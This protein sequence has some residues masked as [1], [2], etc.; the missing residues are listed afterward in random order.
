MVFSIRSQLLY[1]TC[2]LIIQVSVSTKSPAEINSNPALINQLTKQ[3]NQGK[4]SYIEHKITPKHDF[5]KN[6]VAGFSNKPLKTKPKVLKIP[7]KVRADIIY[8]NGKKVIYDLKGKKELILKKILKKQNTKE[9]FWMKKY[10]KPQKFI[11]KIKEK[12]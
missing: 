3:L 8:K 12:L 4:S 6:P 7:P 1:Q 9:K 11:K 5:N 2:F 10:S